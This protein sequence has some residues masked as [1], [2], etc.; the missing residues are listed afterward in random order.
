MDYGV[1]RKTR[2]L[3]WLL[4][5]EESQNFLVSGVHL[6]IDVRRFLP[7]GGLFLSHFEH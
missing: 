5:L 2:G 1:H 3:M 4:P 7:E 6:S